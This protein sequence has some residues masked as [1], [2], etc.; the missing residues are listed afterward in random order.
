M[1]GFDGKVEIAYEKIT[2][3]EKVSETVY[4]RTFVGSFGH[5]EWCSGFSGERKP[6]W[7]GR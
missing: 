3:K 6:A 5:A 7:N 2:T 1:V 4:V